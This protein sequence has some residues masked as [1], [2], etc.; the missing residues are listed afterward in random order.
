MAE[1]ASVWVVLVVLLFGAL[2]GILARAGG[3]KAFGEALSRRLRTRRGV[4][5]GAFGLGVVTFVDDYLNAL[6][7]GA[8]FRGAADRMGISRARLAYVVDSTAAPICVLIPASTWT[9][10][11]AA[12]SKRTGSPRRAAGQS[13]T[14]PHPLS[15]LP[16]VRDPAGARGH[17]GG[18]PRSRADGAAERELRSG[19]VPATAALDESLEPT[20]NQAPARPGLR[21]P[22]F[23][24]P[25]LVLPAATLALGG[26]ALFGVV[27]ALGVALLLTALVR[28]AG[29]LGPVA[30]GAFL[31]MEK[32]VYPSGSC[33]SPSSC[34]T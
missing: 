22:A 3:S 23:L 13:S 5:L 31:G 28:P 4:L 15:P 26:D 12:S 30:D 27:T 2:I 18:G 10:F 9:V 21:T 6:A 19:A 24:I 29:G 7:V 34:G 32:M 14:S 25:I 20:A 1:P 17:P 16:V 33:S 11:I 8:A